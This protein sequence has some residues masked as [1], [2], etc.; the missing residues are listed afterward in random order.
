MPVLTTISTG[1]SV[2][3]IIYDI[4]KMRLSTFHFHLS[5]FTIIYSCCYYQVNQS[6]GLTAVFEDVS[7]LPPALKRI[8][9]DSTQVGSAI[10]YNSIERV[11]EA[12]LSVHVPYSL[13]ITNTS[14]VPLD[15]SQDLLSPSQE[16]C[17]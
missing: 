17:S 4:P 13:Q 12:S 11:R 15:T 6:T 5:L 3:C 10:S 9:T 14:A 2:Y 16:V 7:I 8:T 1:K